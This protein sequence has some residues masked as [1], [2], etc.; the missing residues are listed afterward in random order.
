MRFAK[1]QKMSKDIL[2][3]L[4]EHIKNT[5]LELKLLKDANVKLE[6]EL[7]SLWSLMD[8]LKEADIK[9]YAHLVKQLQE[10][11]IEK[12]LMTTTKKADC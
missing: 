5:E 9:N 2:K 11:Y 12:T 7:D 10:E 1:E 4:K 3:E 8:E 6:D